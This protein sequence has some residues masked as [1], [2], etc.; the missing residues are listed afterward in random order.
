M[1]LFR[2]RLGWGRKKKKKDVEAP[3]EEA[4]RRMPSLGARAAGF[5]GADDDEIKA[6]VQ[7]E[8]CGVLGRTILELI[9]SS[10][11]PTPARDDFNHH[12]TIT[13]PYADVLFDFLARGAPR[14]VDPAHQVL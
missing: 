4:E 10:P 13:R 14:S 8:V 11:A 1:S 2:R 3:A 5:A 7:R 6:K 12:H 9:Q